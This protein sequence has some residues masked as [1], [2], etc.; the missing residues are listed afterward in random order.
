MKTPASG[1]QATFVAEPAGHERG[2]RQATRAATAAVM[3]SALSYGLVLPVLPQLAA[4][5]EPSAVAAA[6]GWLMSSYTLASLVASPAWGIAIDRYGTKACLV[7]GLVGQALT[8]MFLLLSPSWTTLL[9]NRILQ[10]LLGAGIVPA[11]FV[12]V[13]HLAATDEAAAVAIARVTRANLIGAV[14]GPF[15]G[16]VLVRGADLSAAVGADMA[17]AALALIPL[18]RLRLQMPSTDATATPP[19]VGAHASRTGVLLL[20]SAGIAL[21]LGAIEVGVALRGRAILGLSPAELG[22]MFSGCGIVMIAVQTLLFRPGHALVLPPGWI[23]PALWLGAIAAVWLGTARSMWALSLIVA[24]IAVVVGI[25]QPLLSYWLARL[26]PQAA[27]VGFGWRAAISGAGQA[28][29]SLIGG[30]VFLQPNGPSLG[31]LATAV[32]LAA[33]G[34]LALAPRA[35]GATSAQPQVSPAADASTGVRQEKMVP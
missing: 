29:G 4:A 12:L 14:I 33:I 21:T 10:G 26:S 19:S 15:V 7:V 13:T 5:V 18:A 16:G 2:R 3:V 20:L 8:L 27:G 35:T 32:L 9:A 6:T 34:T 17:L 22:L 28:L 30:Y 31:L 11:A 1:A 23:A 24:M 25:A